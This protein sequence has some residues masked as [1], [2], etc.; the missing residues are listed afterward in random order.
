ETPAAGRAY[1]QPAASN[2]QNLP[3][4]PE[5]EVVQRH[6]L[7]AGRPEAV[8]GLR[9]PGHRVHLGLRLL[10]RLDPNVA[11]LA[12]ARTGRDELADDDVLLEADQRVAARVDRRVGD[13]PGGLLE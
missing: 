5:V 11:V 1:A 9:V 4:R 7:P 8:V 13:H 6:S 2:V 3:V 10:G 12:D